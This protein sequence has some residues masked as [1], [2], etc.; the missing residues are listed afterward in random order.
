MPKL[1]V[2]DLLLWFQSARAA[3]TKYHILAD[4][5]KQQKFCFLTVLEAGI[6]RSGGQGSQALGA[7][8]LAYK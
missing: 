3:I 8:F 7:P 6:L 5:L 1:K 2:Q 4:W